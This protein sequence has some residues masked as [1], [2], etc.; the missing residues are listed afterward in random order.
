MKLK[1]IRGFYGREWPFSRVTKS[2][3]GTKSLF[4][5]LEIEGDGKDLDNFEA[6][7]PRVD[8]AG[9]T[10]ES[11]SFS[12]DGGVIGEPIATFT[13]KLYMFLM[14]PIATSTTEAFTEHALNQVRTETVLGKII[15]SYICTEKMNI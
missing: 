2:Q 15:N 7:V 6:V 5:G 12:L 14:E 10:Q 1:K 13:P 3:H 8:K 9:V 11:N 4:A